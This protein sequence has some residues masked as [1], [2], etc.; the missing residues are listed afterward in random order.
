MLPLGEPG[1]LSVGELATPEH[2]EGIRAM[3][4][5]SD[6]FSPRPFPLLD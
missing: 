2:S 3:K 6:S 5:T 1:H 4:E